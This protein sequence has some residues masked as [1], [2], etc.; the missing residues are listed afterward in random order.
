MVPY[1]ELITRNGLAVVVE[2]A[3]TRYK[4]TEKGGECAPVHEGVGGADT[5]AHI[6]AYEFLAKP[7]SGNIE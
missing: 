2:G 4:T 1:I 5:G 6:A 7:S 3:V